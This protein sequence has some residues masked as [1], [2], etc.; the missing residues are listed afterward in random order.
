M[1]NH[2]AQ[3][4]HT[5]PTRT[6]LN[7]VKSECPVFT[8]DPYVDNDPA[9]LLYAKVIMQHE[10]GFNVKEVVQGVIED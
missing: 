7:P 6:E 3:R 2:H 4:N 9:L 5:S 8:V 10:K 1:K